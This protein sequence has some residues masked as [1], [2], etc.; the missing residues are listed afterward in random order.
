MRGDNLLESRAALRVSHGMTQGTERFVRHSDRQS[1]ILGWHIANNAKALE[2]LKNSPLYGNPPPKAHSASSR[3]SEKRFERTPF[4]QYEQTWKPSESRPASEDSLIRQ[5]QDRNPNLHQAP[6]LRSERPESPEIAIDLLIDGMRQRLEAGGT[7]A[8]ANLLQ[9]FKNADVDQSGEL[10][11]NEFVKGLL[12]LGL[13]KTR[14]ECQSV[15]KYYDVDESGNINISEFMDAFRGKLP[16]HRRQVVHEAF[17]QLDRDGNGVLNIEDLKRVYKTYAHPDV[18]AGVR[19]EE[20]VLGEF[21][22][23][24][25]TIHADGSV[26]LAEFEQYYEGLSMLIKSD[27]YFESMLRNTWHLPGAGGG[28]CLRLHIAYEE[29]DPR[30]KEWKI[31]QEHVEI[32]PDIGINRHDPHFFQ[33][34]NERLQEMGYHSVL[35]IEVMG[36]Y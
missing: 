17:A 5:L 14:A 7:S 16:E 28:H 26:G 20:E 18:K 23:V 24:F 36:R 34:C 1:A 10:D 15:F 11:L 35:E 22:S 8:L 19:S 3:G 12:K 33:R 25:D 31:V 6:P 4:F 9:Y 32:R 30:T 13:L 2:R 27:E 29:Q 21:L